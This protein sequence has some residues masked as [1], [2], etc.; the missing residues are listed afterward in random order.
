M[1][2]RI[3]SIASIRNASAIGKRDVKGD[4]LHQGLAPCKPA[5][6]NGGN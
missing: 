2:L 1:I 3:F 6:I 5:R 4:S